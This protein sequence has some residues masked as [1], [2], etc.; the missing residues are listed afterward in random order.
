MW[1]KDPLHNGCLFSSTGIKWRIY[2]AHSTVRE[3][4]L[5][6]YNDVVL[7]TKQL[8][9]R[10]RI[11]NAL[12][13]NLHCVIVESRRLQMY[14]LWS[15]CKPAGDIIA[16]NSGTHNVV[17]FHYADV[18]VIEMTSQITSLA[19]VYSI[20]YSDADQR[21]HQSSASLA[22]V[23]GIH[24]GPMNS[25]HKWPVTRKLFPFDDDIIHWRYGVQGC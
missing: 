2:Q 24:G 8:I 15:Y 16:I 12:P 9:D 22:F 17:D 7:L 10:I 19:I 21:K 5:R 4:S 20:V 6:R 3:L 14:V 1:L 13:L 23:R 18:I 11:T 25:P